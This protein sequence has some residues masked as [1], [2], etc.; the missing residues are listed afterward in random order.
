M[1]TIIPPEPDLE[2]EEEK[3]ARL[4]LEYRTWHAIHDRHI[5]DYRWHNPDVF[6]ARHRRFQRVVR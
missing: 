3:A 1:E 4:D 5:A 6:A 2:T